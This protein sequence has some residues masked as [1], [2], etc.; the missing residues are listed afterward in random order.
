MASHIQYTLY[1]YGSPS[2]TGNPTFSKTTIKNVSRDYEI[3]TVEKNSRI[4]IQFSCFLQGCCADGDAD[5]E[6]ETE[7]QYVTLFFGNNSLMDFNLFGNINLSSG[8]FL[9]SGWIIKTKC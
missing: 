7:S 8:L 4:L 1:V 9:F 5:A 3:M 6:C 2:S